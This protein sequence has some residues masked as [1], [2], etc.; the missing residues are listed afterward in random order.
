MDDYKDRWK[1]FKLPDWC[2]ESSPAEHGLIGSVVRI[3]TAVVGMR[4]GEATGPSVRD[5]VGLSLDLLTPVF[6]DAESRGDL[7]AV[8]STRLGR[9]AVHYYPG[10]QFVAQP[11]TPAPIELPV[12]DLSVPCKRCGAEAD[13]R[14]ESANGIELTQGTH[15]VRRRAASAARQP[16]AA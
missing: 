6:D 8:T 15:Q 4:D 2:T 12:L 1:R 9:T 3:S 14:C 10:D 16:G 13:E 5:F 7:V 11:V